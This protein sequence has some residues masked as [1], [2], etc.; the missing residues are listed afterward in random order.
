MGPLF[1]VLLMLSR[2][3]A[4]KEAVP[5]HRNVLRQPS[6]EPIEGRGEEDSM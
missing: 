6:M 2:Q 4:Q 1:D 3:E 5:D